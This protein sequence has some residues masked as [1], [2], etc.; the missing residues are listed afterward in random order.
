MNKCSIRL[1][2]IKDFNNGFTTKELIDKYGY[3]KTTINDWLRPTRLEI[4]NNGLKELR[5]KF[6]TLS[7]EFEIMKI[8]LEIYKN[9]ECLPSSKRIDK[10]NAIEKYYNI[11][12]VKTMCRILDVSVG[13]FYNHLNRRVEEKSNIKRDKILKPLVLEV[14]NKSKQ[15]FGSVKIAQ[16]LRNEGHTISN[17]KSK[18]LMNELNI[19]PILGKKKKMDYSN[20]ESKNK[21]LKNKVGRNFKRDNPNE[22]WATDVTEVDVLD[23]VFF[24]CVI[25]DLFS[26]KVIGYRVHCKNNTKLVINTLKDAYE[27]RNAP[28][29]VIVHSDRGSNYTSFKYRSLLKSLKLIPSYSKTARP[30]ENAVV[31]SF[32]SHFKKEEIYKNDYNTLEELTTSVDEYIAFF[33]D[34]RPHHHLNGQ[35]P[36]NFESKYIIKNGLVAQQC[37]KSNF[38]LEIKKTFSSGQLIQKGSKVLL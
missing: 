18:Q 31:E 2:V 21:Y 9:L 24:V 25:L 32:F 14:Y 30:T 15:R 4:E 13:T 26:R 38:A 20:I 34:Y 27:N 33:N 10:L 7:K 36:N 37:D 6:S 23:N 16:V 35:T 5:K 12:P 29:N 11:Y 3:S 22:V 1:N 19:K 8:E 28:S 17:N